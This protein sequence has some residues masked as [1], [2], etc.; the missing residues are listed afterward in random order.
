MKLQLFCLNIIIKGNPMDW[1][2]F[3][4]L[5]K[6]QLD[7]RD[8]RREN[9]GNFHFRETKFYGI[10]GHNV[11]KLIIFHILNVIISMES[12]YFERELF[13]AISTMAFLYICFIAT[14]G[15]SFVNSSCLP[16]G[17]VANLA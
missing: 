8:V 11:E 6:D 13:Y 12:Q 17:G 4:N 14:K 7:L 9:R 3:L 5:L 1:Q 16:C 10:M 2:L 15:F